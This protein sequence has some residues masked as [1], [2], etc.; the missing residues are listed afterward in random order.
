L[1]LPSQLEAKT[2][3]SFP[4]FGFKTETK[5]DAPVPDTPTLLERI[6][7]SGQGRTLCD[8]KKPTFTH[9]INNDYS[10]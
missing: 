7:L 1:Q 5:I 8:P 4:T 2:I 9:E 10:E 6:G 3:L